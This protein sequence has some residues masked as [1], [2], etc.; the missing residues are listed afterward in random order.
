MRAHPPTPLQV[1]RQVRLGWPRNVVHWVATQCAVS[2]RQ[3]LAHR[4]DA[5][6]RGLATALHVT[7]RRSTATRARGTG[8][9]MVRRAVTE[10]AGSVERKPRTRQGN[11][12]AGERAL[13]PDQTSAPGLSAP[14]IP[15]AR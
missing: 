4:G 3:L 5:R 13:S 2:D 14:T 11:W 1:S 10:R 12:L 6:A 9:L 15:S 8:S 7:A